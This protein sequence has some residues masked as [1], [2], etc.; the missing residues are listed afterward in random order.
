MTYAISDRRTRRVRSKLN[1]E[2]LSKST[3][4]PSV[5]STKEWTEMQA[6][7]TGALKPHAEAWAAVAKALKEHHSKYAD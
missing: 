2:T 1:S 7:I 5:W 3:N 6:A 4:A